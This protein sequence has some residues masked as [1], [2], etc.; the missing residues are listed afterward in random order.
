MITQARTEATDT[1]APAPTPAPPGPPFVPKRLLRNFLLDR[2]QLRYT[3]IIVLIGACLIG[4]LGAVVYSKAHEATEAAIVT[5][6]GSVEDG[7]V[8]GDLIGWFRDSDRKLIWT[9]SGFGVAL[10]VLL[11]G[12][13][14]VITH[15]VAGPIY[16]MTNYFNAIR[17][18]RLGPVH[19]LRKGDQLVEFYEAFRQMHDRLRE[20][21]KEEI[22]IL[23]RVAAAPGTAESIAALEELKR[24]KEGSL[25]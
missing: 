15:K 14:I 12:Y 10:C 7:R 4:G 21:T 22:A 19:N 8:R 1:V 11:A 23:E 24:R 6:Q 5:V 3:A 9:L 17:D 18:G 20:R 16:K 13:G 2:M 25:Q